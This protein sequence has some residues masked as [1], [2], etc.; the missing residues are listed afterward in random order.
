MQITANQFGSVSII[1]F[2]GSLDS[3][4]AP[5]ADEFLHSL[6]RA[7]SLK[8]VLNFMYLDFLT[9]AGLRVIISILKATRAQGGDLRLANNHDFVTNTLEVTGLGGTI[10]IFETTEEAVASF[11]E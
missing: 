9:S 3:N 1:N 6:V 5:K 10:Q 11:S 4:T 7:G 8:L 2:V